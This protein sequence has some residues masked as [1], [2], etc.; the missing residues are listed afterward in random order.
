MRF[1]MKLCAAAVAFGVMSMGARA[2]EKLYVY[3]SMKDSI[4]N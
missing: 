1:Q 4:T 2:Q 3:T